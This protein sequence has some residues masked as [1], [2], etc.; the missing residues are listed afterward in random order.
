MPV[1]DKDFITVVS[2]L[3]RSGTSMMM[4]MLDQ[5]GMPT[6]TDGFRQADEDNPLG[7]YEFEPVKRLGKDDSW[8][9]DAYNKV[10]KIIYIF[11]YKLPPEHRYKVIFMMRNLDEVV[12]SQKTMLRRRQEG[13]RL[14]DDQL[15]S[16]FDEQL[17]QLDLWIR[18]QPNFTVLYVNYEVVIRDPAEA[19][20][21]I[22]QFL[23]LPLDTEAMTRSVEP[24]LHRNRS[25]EG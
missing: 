21:D 10:V 12:A 17:Q 2:G 15:V 14:S 22:A 1:T 4:R 13:D 16:S 7:Y 11:L 9:P 19:S 8:L 25:V 20:R 18:K 6:I 5:G 23:G 24:A 3:P